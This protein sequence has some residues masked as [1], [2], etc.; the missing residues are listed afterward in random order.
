MFLF[1]PSIETDTKTTTERAHL[2]QGRH[3]GLAR[4]GLALQNR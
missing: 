1:H 4:R 2:Y 3:Y